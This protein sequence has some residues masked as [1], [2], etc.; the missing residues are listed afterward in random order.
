MTDLG[1]LAGHNSYAVGINDSAVVV[2]ESTLTANPTPYHAFLHRPRH[3]M[4][5]LGTLGGDNSI[6]VAI[7]GSGSVVGN[8]SVSGGCCFAFVWTP[9]GGMQNLGPGSTSFSAAIGMNSLG[10]SWA[11]TN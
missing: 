8:S 1:A 3:R 2:G 6:A 4:V 7:N 10:A 5:D 9:A 11:T